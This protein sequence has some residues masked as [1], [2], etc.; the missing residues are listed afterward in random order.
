LKK[1]QCPLCYSEL[2]IKDFAPC[3]DCGGFEEEINH[4][5]EGIHKYNIYD[6]Y[7]GLKLQLC[8]F[9]DIDFGSYLPEYFGFSGSNPIGYENFIFL[10]HVN[11]PYIQKSKYCPECNKGLRFLT[12]V[13]DLR[14]MVKDQH[15]QNNK[16]LLPN[17]NKE[18]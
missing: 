8:N 18:K 10:S 4:F 1:E 6:V 17:S 5:K 13:R 9:C 15:S 3:D 11:N 2:K 12:F 7:N 16:S 14:E